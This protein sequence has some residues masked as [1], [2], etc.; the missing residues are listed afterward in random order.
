MDFRFMA[1]N[2]LIN[3]IQSGTLIQKLI[4]CKVGYK[5]LVAGDYLLKL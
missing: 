3:G 1:L 4:T 5:F 2:D